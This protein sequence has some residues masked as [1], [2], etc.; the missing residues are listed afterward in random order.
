MFLIASF[1]GLAMAA[2]NCPDFPS[3]HCPGDL[4]RIGDN[5]PG[6]GQGVC[7][8]GKSCVRSGSSE[9]WVCLQVLYPLISLTTKLTFLISISIADSGFCRI[10]RGCYTCISILAV[11]RS[12]TCGA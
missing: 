5:K 7:C 8:E 1:L 10:A 6:D 3:C 4:C 9:N 11:V 2:G 12:S